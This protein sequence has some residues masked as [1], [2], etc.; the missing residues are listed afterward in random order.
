MSDPLSVTAG[1]AGLV[2]LG[3]ETTQYLVK[4]YTAYRTRDHE[5]ARTAGRLGNLLQSLHTVDDIVRTRTWRTNEKTILQNFEQSISRCEDVINELQ[6]EVQKLQKEPADSFVQFTRA[7][8]RRAAYPF[9]Q[10]TLKKLDEDV[11]EFRDNVSIAL[12]ALQLK[13]HQNTQDDIEEMR[14][15]VTT[16]QAQQVVTDVRDW[17]RAADATIDY[18]AACLKR[19][20]GTGQWFIQSTTFTTWLEQDNSFLWLYGFAGC[21]KS[22]L[23]STV[24]QHTFRHQRS[25]SGSVLAFFFF[26]FNDKSKQD[27][28]A[29]LHVLLLQLSG[30]VAGM[31]TD[32]KRLKDSYSNGTP[33]VPIL[34][35]YLRSAMTRSHDVYLLLDALDEC[36]TGDTRD[37]VLS[38]IQTIRQWSL[39]SLHLLITSRDT[40]DIRQT[41]NVEIDNTVVLTDDNVSQDIL[42]YV[43][44]QVDYGPRLKRWGK[45]RE[46]IKQSL[47]QRANGV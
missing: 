10:S 18:N 27:V 36:P 40:I 3:L 31:E 45:H 15:I 44:H 22:V 2:A 19:H 24:I 11:D 29:M 42:R 32:L 37:Y 34:M 5:L 25:Q 8:G 21:G 20:T 14:K 7:V 47:A 39:P 41:L 46:T 13:E 4:Y 1:I 26:T 28:S 16:V 33:P 12:Q 17:L 30:Q 23:C 43:S 38:T 9:R 6:V 35:E